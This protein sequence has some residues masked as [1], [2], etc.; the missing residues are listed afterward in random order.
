MENKLNGKTVKPFKTTEKTY[1]YEQSELIIIW[2][3]SSKHD[4][5]FYWT[6]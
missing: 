6:E 2:E 1:A 3:T 4:D 5:I